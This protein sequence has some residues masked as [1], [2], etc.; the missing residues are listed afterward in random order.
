MDSKYKTDRPPCVDIATKPKYEVVK[1]VGIQADKLSKMVVLVIANI[2]GSMKSIKDKKTLGGHLQGIMTVKGKDN[3]ESAF[4]IG[5]DHSFGLQTGF[6]HNIKGKED[7][8]VEM[9]V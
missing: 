5:R 9:K 7:L 8:K 2:A 1:G 3:K 4:E 6:M